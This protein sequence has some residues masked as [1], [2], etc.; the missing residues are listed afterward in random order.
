M[1]T[2]VFLNRSPRN[3]FTADLLDKIMEVLYDVH[4]DYKACNVRY[5]YNRCVPNKFL[6]P[7]CDFLMLLESLENF[8]YCRIFYAH[9]GKKLDHIVALSDAKIVN[10]IADGKIDRLDITEMKINHA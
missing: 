4:R 7:Y 6:M 10:D 8:G 3:T 2:Y 9:N 1:S 5:V